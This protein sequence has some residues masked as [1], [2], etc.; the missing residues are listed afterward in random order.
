MANFKE[1]NSASKEVVII[2]EAL[3]AKNRTVADEIITSGSFERDGRVFEKL[4]V[5]RRI[6]LESSFGEGSFIRYE[7]WLP[8]NWN[9]VFVGCGN[10]GM[11]GRLSYAE[12]SNYSRMGYAVAH[13]DMGTSL[14]VESGV[15]NRVLWKD[16][17][18]RATHYMTVEAKRLIRSH[19]GRDAEFSYFIGS[20]TGGQQALCLAQRF[21]ED[22]DGI[23]AGVPA[24][25][26]I[27]LQ[28]YFLWARIHM[29]KRDGQMLFTP[30]QLDEA[31][32]AAVDWFRSL[33]DGEEGDRFVSFPYADR[34]TVDEFVCYLNEK[35]SL[36]EEQ[37]EALRAI[38]NGPVNPKTGDQLNCG[39]PIGSE[40][41]GMLRKVESDQ[42]GNSLYLFRWA[43][44]MDYDLYDF[45]FADDVERMTGIF[46]GEI[47][48]N[49]P[50]LEAFRDRGG[51]LIAFSG[52]SDPIG[53]YPEFIKYYHRVCDEMGGC[54]DVKGFFRYFLLP[55]K[56]HGRG[57]KGTNRWWATEQH[58]DMICAMREWCEEGRAPQ[59][60]TAARIEEG[61]TVFER[62]V[63][64][65]SCEREEGIGFP[66]SCDE[67]YLNM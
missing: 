6:A 27:F 20:S 1:Y 39:M 25:N 50:D 53:P 32:A 55:G 16:F 62:K 23:I 46:D 63:R 52:S 11:A 57:G 22:Y 2:V 35:T 30:E 48:A 28:I 37:T 43:F 13:T 9:G 36:S 26:R 18:W 31:E 60:M 14:G 51:K 45:D 33:G 38:Y 10:G 56:D 29:R 41:C 65:Y 17:G 66:K 44:G 58:G 64:P 42:T 54:E 34:N 47:N 40:S 24:N 4:P 15:G 12:L 49:D 61:E 19:Y 8:E 7:F 21:P 5:F 59:F 67:R 3:Q